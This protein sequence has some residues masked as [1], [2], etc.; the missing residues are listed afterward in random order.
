MLP[1]QDKSGKD[2]NTNSNIRNIKSSNTI[3]PNLT[4][5]NSKYANDDS[6]VHHP[7]TP[8][9]NHLHS[10]IP[11]FNIHHSPTSESNSLHSN[12]L[13]SVTPDSVNI[14]SNT[15]QT[16][17][18]SKKKKTLLN[19]SSINKIKTILNITD[20]FKENEKL[21]TSNKHIYS[22]VLSN[23]LYHYISTEQNG[24]TEDTKNTGSNIENPNIK[25]PILKELLTSV[26]RGNSNSVTDTNAT[27]NSKTN[28]SD[29]IIYVD[30]GNAEIASGDLWSLN[31]L[32]IAV[33]QFRSKKRISQTISEALVTIQV[34]DDKVKLSFIEGN[35]DL[36]F[37]PMI[38][39]KNDLLNEVAIDS[40]LKTVSVDAVR[41]L[42]ELKAIRSFVENNNIKNSSLVI[43]GSLV[44]HNSLDVVEISNLAKLSN[45]NNCFL[46][47]ISK[48]SQMQTNQF[49]N[50]NDTVNYNADKNR[51]FLFGPFSQYNDEF[52]TKINISIIKL[53]PKADYSFRFDYFSGYNIN[54]N[55][56]NRMDSASLLEQLSLHLPQSIKNKVIE[57]LNVSREPSFLG[58][59]YGLIFADRIA[60]VSYEE[61]NFIKTKFKSFLSKEERQLFTKQNAHSFLDNMS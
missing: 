46:S 8:D 44:P 59:P 37:N 19:T 21:V 17:G 56:L 27:D 60:R 47:G 31:Q 39:E 42:L 45:A 54:Q 22:L 23:N 41:R 43:D 49:R 11:H 28:H 33:V 34:V 12:S 38:I 25:D 3:H 55:N 5:P 26:T 61:T 24:F 2:T 15:N 20:G 52:G 48:S 51:S 32:R 6:N 7:A 13:H 30:G 10:N 1:Y 18:L 36:L 29:Y 14:N 57:L 40:D 35:D 16:N 4:N 50:L 9:S 53:H 58:Y